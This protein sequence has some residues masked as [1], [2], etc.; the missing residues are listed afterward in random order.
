MSKKKIK[1]KP[2]KKIAEI[3]NSFGPTEYIKDEL[4]KHVKSKDKTKE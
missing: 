1:H 4:F 2:D 3:A